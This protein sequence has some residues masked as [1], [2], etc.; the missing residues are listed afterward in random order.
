MTKRKLS[1]RCWQPS[2]EVDNNMHR[3]RRG[4]FLQHQLC[5]TLYCDSLESSVPQHIHNNHI[6]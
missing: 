6:K 2:G 4:M 1:S 3:I 5:F